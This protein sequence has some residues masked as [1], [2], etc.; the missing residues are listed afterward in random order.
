MFLG[1]LT[2]RIADPIAR[3][4]LADA[5]GWDEGNRVQRRAARTRREVLRSYARRLPSR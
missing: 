5:A 3:S 4:V 1:R 2:R